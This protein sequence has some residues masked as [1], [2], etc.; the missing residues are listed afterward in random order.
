MTLTE[1]EHSLVPGRWLRQPELS[2]RGDIPQTGTRFANP[3]IDN[4]HSMA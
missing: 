1:Y 2:S 4:C 3:D